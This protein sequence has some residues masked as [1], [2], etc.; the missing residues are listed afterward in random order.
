MNIINQPTT[1]KI[2]YRLD[3]QFLSHPK[4]Y[5]YEQRIYSISPYQLI[6]LNHIKSLPKKHLYYLVG[7]QSIKHRNLTLNELR[8]LIT[9][10]IRRYIKNT[11]L[12]Y[13]PGLE[14]Q[15]VKYFCIFETTKDFYHSQHQNTILNNEVDMG[16][17]FHL[18]ISSPDNYPW[19]CFHSLIFTIFTELTYLPKNHRCISKYDYDRINVLNENFILYHTKQFKDHPSKEMIMTNLQTPN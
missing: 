10:G 14:N 19:V 1:N 16:L 15:L 7:Q 2:L 12:T 5:E 8:K 4:T 3:T 13:Y 9:T 17:H 11:T 6:I 18:F